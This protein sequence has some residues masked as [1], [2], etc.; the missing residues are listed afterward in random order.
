MPLIPP[1]IAAAGVAAVGLALKPGSSTAP[2]I[3]VAPAIA[4]AT[5]TA[6][7][8][9]DKSTPPLQIR[10]VL[11]PQKAMHIGRYRSLLGTL[12]H[13]VTYSRT[14]DA[15]ADKWDRGVKPGGSAAQEQG[16]MSEATYGC[17]HQ[18]GLSD[19]RIF[20]P[21]W[22]V[23]QK[24]VDMQVDHVVELQVIPAAQT[25]IWDSFVNYELLDAKSNQSSG[26]QLMNNIQAERN[27]LQ[28]QT[29]NPIWQTAPLV[30]TTVVPSSGFGGL[31][32]SADEIE[33]GDHIVPYQR[34]YLGQVTCRPA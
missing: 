4:T 30:F 29:G 20:R 33:R 27:R 13:D 23:R 7:T 15:Q 12:V 2:A 3:G 14:V 17:G 34:L 5:A 26:A 1:P 28:A 6:S 32:W 31:R 25:T 21:N 16:G 19:A 10:L 9:K 11:P 24:D 8:P 22:T 18:L